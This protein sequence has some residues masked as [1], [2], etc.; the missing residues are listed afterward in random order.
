MGESMGLSSPSALIVFLSHCPPS[1]VRCQLSWMLK[2]LLVTFWGIPLTTSSLF[3]LPRRSFP[4][5]RA[6]LRSSSALFPRPT[7][8]LAVFFFFLA[9]ML[10]VPHDGEYVLGPAG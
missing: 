1:S 6:L 10:V 2:S 9:G 5:L 7:F 3:T 8:F 4:R